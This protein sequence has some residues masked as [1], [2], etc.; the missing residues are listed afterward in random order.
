MLYW[1]VI[2][3]QVDVHETVIFK[4]FLSACNNVFL[5][6]F[7][8][9]IAQSACI[10]RVYVRPFSRESEFVILYS[11][12]ETWHSTKTAFCRRRI[13]P[14]YSSNFAEFRG[15]WGRRE[16][17]NMKRKAIKGTSATERMITYMTGDSDAH[18][19][20][21]LFFFFVFATH[22][23][24]GSSAAARSNKSEHRTAPMVE[25]RGEREIGPMT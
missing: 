12:T 15:R 25:M 6:V 24:P 1:H 13:R 20:Y 4:F 22:F 10:A 2:D 5:F 18:F 16:R 11:Q 3:L 8:I 23:I 17:R 7:K 21:P 19:S 9:L 14:R